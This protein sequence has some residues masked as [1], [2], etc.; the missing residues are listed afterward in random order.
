[1]QTATQGNQQTNR[2][3]SEG[4]GGDKLKNVDGDFPACMRLRIAAMTTQEKNEGLKGRRG[5]RLKHYNVDG[6]VPLC[7]RKTERESKD[8]SSSNEK[9]RD[10]K[11]KMMSGSKDLCR[12]STRK[13]NDETAI[14]KEVTF[15]VLQKIDQCTQR[16]EEMICELE[17]YRWDAISLSETWRQDKAEI[18]R[19]ITNTYSWVQ[20]DTTTDTAFGIMLNKKWRQRIIDTE[21]INE[22]AISTTIVVNRQRIKLMSVYFTHSGYADHHMEKMYKMIEKHTASYK[23]Y[24][25]II[26]G[27]FNAELAPGHGT[28]CI[29]VDRYT[30]NEGNKRGDWM[31]HWLMLRA[32]TQHSTRCTERHLRNKRPSYLQKETKNKSTTY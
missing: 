15:I 27:D 7:L 1:M 22:R 9:N 4:G 16:I 6:D 10:D 17:G 29:S 19:F 24:I 3:T 21:Y 14:N 30:L 31:K 26:G 5:G 32:S 11:S 18:G 28:E 20:E 12:D 13:R 25:P 23:R 8:G 2:S